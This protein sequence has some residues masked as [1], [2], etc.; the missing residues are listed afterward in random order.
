MA[1]ILTKYNFFK[2]GD[3]VFEND[4][5]KRSPKSIRK[6]TDVLPN[7]FLK[8]EGNFKSLNFDGR[9]LNIGYLKN[10]LSGDDKTLVQP[11]I[12]IISGAKDIRGVKAAVNYIARFVA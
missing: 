7:N 5:L 10:M 9:F 11:V 4:D 2:E 12:K 1:T 3:P 8:H 6:P